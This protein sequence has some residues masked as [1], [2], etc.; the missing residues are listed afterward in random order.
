MSTRRNLTLVITDP[1]PCLHRHPE[2]EQ[3]GQIWFVTCPSCHSVIE[4]GC[5]MYAKT[6]A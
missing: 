3:V 6:S 2:L 5:Q 4:T 1:T